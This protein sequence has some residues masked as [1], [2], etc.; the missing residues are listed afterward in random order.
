MYDILKR[1]PQNP[2]RIIFA[3]TALFAAA[4][5]L[6]S[7]GNWACLFMALVGGAVL[8]CGI[9]TL[10][11]RWLDWKPLDFAH[12]SHLALLLFPH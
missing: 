9:Y 5:A 3:T 1:G 7:G 10:I 4:V 6:V 2:S 11:R 12:L 8:Q